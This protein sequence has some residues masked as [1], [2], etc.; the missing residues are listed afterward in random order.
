M[1]QYTALAAL[2]EQTV[3]DL[4]DVDQRVNELL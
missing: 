1:S 2:I 4:K 3:V